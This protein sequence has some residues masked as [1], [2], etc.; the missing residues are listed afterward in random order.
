MDIVTAIGEV[1]TRLLA[2]TITSPIAESVRK[3]WDP[4]PPDSVALPELPCWILSRTLVDTERNASQY[5]EH[6]TLHLQFFV[7]DAD[8]D[9]ALKIARA[10]EVAAHSAFGPHPTLSGKVTNQLLRG[11]SPT[12]GTAERNSIV[13]TV[14]DLYMDVTIK[15]ALAFDAS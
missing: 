3:V 7:R 5:I 13:Y 11:G 4:V 14:L 1:N 2:L 9:R 15:N 6:H 8:R 12:E 10:F